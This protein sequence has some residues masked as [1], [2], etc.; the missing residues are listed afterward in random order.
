MGF[1]IWQ[2][3]RSAP[4][5][6]PAPAPVTPAAAP[7]PAPTPAVAPES[8]TPVAPAPAAIDPK[9]VEAEV[10]RQVAAKRRE[11]EKAAAAKAASEA[12]AAPTAEPAPTEEPTAVPT[13]VPTRPEPTAVPTEIPTLAEATV[14]VR[15][16]DLVGPGAG[17]VEPVLVSPP[18]VVYPAIARQQRIEGKVVVL[19]LVDENGNVTETRL[20]Q[21]VSQTLVNNAVMAGA[22]S[23]KFRPA[24]KNGLAV[25]M[26]RPLIVEVRP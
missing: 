2:T 6:V 22:K 17:V 12:A 1:L 26:W 16:G 25:K 3:T 20:Q 23:A 19:V 7:A 14:E 24:T 21:G 5:A 13:A 8:L 9:A 18:R 11:L 10:Q 4:S 15:R